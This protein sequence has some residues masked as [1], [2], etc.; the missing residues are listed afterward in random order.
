MHYKSEW[1]GQAKDAADLSGGARTASHVEM[2]TDF[3]VAGV[4]AETRRRTVRLQ[5]ELG[6]RQQ[7]VGSATEA[8]AQC[9]AVARHVHLGNR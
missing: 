7:H 6:R 2:Q 1:A 9:S 5:L 8:G 4:G 3:S